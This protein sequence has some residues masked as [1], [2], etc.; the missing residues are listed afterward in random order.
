MSWCR[1]R[2]AAGAPACPA[3]LLFELEVLFV[4]VIFALVTARASH[5]TSVGTLCAA[6]AV[7]ITQL[8]SPLL[9]GERASRLPPRC[10]RSHLGINGT[11]QHHHHINHHYHHRRHHRRCCSHQPAFPPLRPIPSARRRSARPCHAA[12]TQAGWRR[13]QQA[14]PGIRKGKGFAVVSPP[15]GPSDAASAAVWKPPHE[16]LVMPFPCSAMSAPRSR[17]NNA[18]PNTPAAS[19]RARECSAAAHRRDPACHTC[20]SA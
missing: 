20:S 1:Q 16:M 11:L 17:C 19:S 4:A 6:T 9:G 10:P 13:L 7:K 14:S 15:S 5:L 18:P 3:Q 2:E 8:P 12:H